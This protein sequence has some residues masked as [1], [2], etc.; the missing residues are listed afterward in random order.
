MLTKVG[1]THP[2]LICTDCGQPVDQRESASLARK[3]LWGAFTLVGLTLVSGAVLWLASI[4]ERRLATSPEEASEQRAEAG[5]EGEARGEERATLMEPSAL[6]RSTRTTAEAP[7][8]GAEARAHG[9]E[10]AGA[11]ARAGEGEKE[12]AQKRAG[13]QE[14]AEAAG[15]GAGPRTLK[16]SAGA[17]APVA[18]A[19]QEQEQQHHAPQH[20][21]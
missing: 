7:G 15:H 10:R 18:P 14:R 19:A 20:K 12:R 5:G 1:R 21:P 6:M 8:R 11:E 16:V 13:A 2:M 3:R 17:T 9:Q 4:E